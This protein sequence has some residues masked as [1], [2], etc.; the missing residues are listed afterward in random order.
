MTDDPDNKTPE[1]DDRQ[2]R[3]AEP[4]QAS[5]RNRNAQARAPRKADQRDAR[6]NTDQ[7]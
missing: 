6:H 5:L 3:L 7:G 4:Q 2:A 1:K